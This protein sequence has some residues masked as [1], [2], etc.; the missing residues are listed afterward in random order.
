MVLMYQQL[1]LSKSLLRTPYFVLVLYSLPFSFFYSPLI[2]HGY[3]NLGRMWTS[4]LYI[5]LN[6]VT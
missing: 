3:Y 5:R 2:I 1:T 6:M 4:S